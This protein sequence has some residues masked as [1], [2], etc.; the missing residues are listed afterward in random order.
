M[1]VCMNICKYFCTHVYMFVHAY[2]Y[3]YIIGHGAK[4]GVFIKKMTNFP[5]LSTTSFMY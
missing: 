4:F 3:I 5:Q 1:C 2:I